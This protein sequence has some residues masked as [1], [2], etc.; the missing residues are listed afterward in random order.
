MKKN[1][2]AGKK[3]MVGHQVLEFINASTQHYIYIDTLHIIN[4]L[5]TISC[6]RCN[7]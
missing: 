5:H 1:M 7:K 4:K 2:L 3:T 6:L